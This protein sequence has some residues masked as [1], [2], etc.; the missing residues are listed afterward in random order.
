MKGIF[1][2]WEQLLHTLT[3]HISMDGEGG[4]AAVFLLTFS[5]CNW[6]CWALPARDALL[7]HSILA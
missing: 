3:L 6:A 4:G 1:M 5:L 2:R 7:V